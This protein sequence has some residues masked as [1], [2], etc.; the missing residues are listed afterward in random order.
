MA[1]TDIL[2]LTYKDV[3]SNKGF[4]DDITANFIGFIS[5]EKGE[6]FP[7]LGKEINDTMSGYTGKFFANDVISSKYNFIGILFFKKEISDEMAN[8]IFETIIEYEHCEVYSV[9]YNF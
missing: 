8:E 7:K 1:I 2:C 3:L 6:T 9:D 5:W 4:K